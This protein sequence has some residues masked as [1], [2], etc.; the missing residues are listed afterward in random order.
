I[1]WCVMD[2]E[3]GLDT[4]LDDIDA[5]F[6]GR[7]RYDLWGKYIPDQQSSPTD[8][9]LWEKVHS[10]KKYVFSKKP[11]AEGSVTYIDTD[12]VQ[13]VV[14][15]KRQ[16]GKNIWLY[17]GANLITS[18]INYGLIDIFRLAVHPVILGA[19]KPLFSQIESRHNLH[20][21]QVKSHKSGV[22]LLSYDAV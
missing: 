2:E 7:K 12:V 17:G 8:K 5:I 3:I 1:D 11:G 20:L 6:Y 10:K 9:A 21:T 15:I 16:S 4:F 14:E 19:G 22:V 13:R 18:F